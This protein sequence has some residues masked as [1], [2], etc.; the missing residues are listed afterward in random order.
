MLCP[1]WSVGRAAVAVP[2]TAALKAASV[3]PLRKISR[4]LT[5]VVLPKDGCC[6]EKSSHID[7]S[8]ASRPSKGCHDVPKNRFGRHRHEC[9][10]H[11]KNWLCHRI[12]GHS[13]PFLLGT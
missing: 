7:M 1:L 12:C 4:R 2:R 9:L 6:M 13:Y 5:A 8:A 11:P 3:P 10:F